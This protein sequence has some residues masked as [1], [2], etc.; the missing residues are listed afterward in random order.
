MPR[1]AS[2]EV[3]T[4]RS[5]APRAAKALMVS[6]TALYPAGCRVSAIVQPPMSNT[7]AATAE[8]TAQRGIR[9]ISEAYVGPPQLPGSDSQTHTVSTYPRLLA[10]STNRPRE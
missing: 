6:R 10:G 2:A 1:P 5:V 7:G 4:H 9:F 8:A 3:I